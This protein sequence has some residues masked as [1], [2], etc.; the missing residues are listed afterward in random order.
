MENTTIDVSI[1]ERK[2]KVDRLT[3]IDLAN[4]IIK[5]FTDEKS[6]KLTSEVI[7]MVRDFEGF[8]DKAYQCSAGVWTL[9][10][11]HTRGVKKGM[12][13][14]KDQA[15]MWLSEDL[16]EAEAAVIKYVKV[17]L[18]DN[19]YGALVD[20]TFNLGQGSLASS[21]LLRLLNDGD[22]TKAA[23]QF[24]RWVKADGNVIEG[25]VRRREAEKKLFLS[26]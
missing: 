2:F 11:G 8:R 22:Y 10:Y 3:A 26:A 25:L 24:T 18:T 12:T 23:D 13:C 16:G 7:Q 9:G 19:Q 21:T 4:Y 14:T 6:N 5:A 15:D 20:F 1:G 17:P